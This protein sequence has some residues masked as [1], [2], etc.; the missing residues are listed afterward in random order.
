MS[1]EVSEATVSRGHSQR[2]FLQNELA[3]GFTVGTPGIINF[4][5]A[6]YYGIFGARFSVG[7]LG[8]P[9]IIGMMGYDAE[10][11]TVLQRTSSSVLDVGIFY[12]QIIT[13]GGFSDPTF[14]N[15][16]TGIAVSFNADGYFFQAGFGHVVHSNY[17]TGA[18]TSSSKLINAIPLSMQLGYIH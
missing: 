1:Q 3:Y 17:S 11:V 18:V 6:W 8:L 12:S 7:G 4:I 16:C 10:F 15:N 13:K 9:E 14:L 2:R 5:T